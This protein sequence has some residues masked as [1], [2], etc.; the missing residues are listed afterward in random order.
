M[1]KIIALRFNAVDELRLRTYGAKQQVNVILDESQSNNLK[2]KNKIV[3]PTLL[4]FWDVEL[5]TQE[6]EIQR[7]QKLCKSTVEQKHPLL[8][9]ASD[10]FGLGN[11]KA[12]GHAGKVKRKKKRKKRAKIQRNGF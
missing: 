6:I 5:L 4:E 11:N 2:S 1:C 12:K 3:Q 9:V 7:L 10:V 8:E